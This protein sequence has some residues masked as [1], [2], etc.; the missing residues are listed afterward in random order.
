M[1]IFRVGSCLRGL[2]PKLTSGA[3]PKREQVLNRCVLSKELLPGTP[4]KILGKLTSHRASHTAGAQS[5]FC[6]EMK[7]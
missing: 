7:Q 5:R 1:S 6:E 4:Q 3:V 2:C